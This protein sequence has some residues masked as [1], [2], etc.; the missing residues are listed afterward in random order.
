[1]M[2]VSKIS[3][4]WMRL[5][6]LQTME[7]LNHSQF[8]PEGVLLLLDPQGKMIEH[9]VMTD[10]R[11]LSLETCLEKE[12]AVEGFCHLI[13]AASNVFHS[14]RAQSCMELISFGES[15]TSHALPILDDEQTLAAVIVWLLPE[16]HPHQNALAVLECIHMMMKCFFRSYTCASSPD[17]KFE[18][19]ESKIRQFLFDFTKQLHSLIHVEDVLKVLIEQMDTMYPGTMFKLWMSQDNHMDHLPLHLL[20]FQGNVHDATKRAYIEGKA[21]YDRSDQE[22]R[23]AVPLLG[24]QAVYG[25]IELVDDRGVLDRADTKLISLLADSTGTAFENAKLHEESNLLISELRLINEMTHKLN[26]SLKP[27]EIYDFTHKELIDIFSADFCSV[28]EVDACQNKIGVRAGNVNEL[29]HENFSLDYGISGLMYHSKE[30]LIFSD[31]NRDIHVRSKFMDITAAKSIMA[32]PMIVRSEVIGVILLAHHEPNYFTYNNYRLFQVLSGHIGLAL[33]NAELHAEVKRMVITDRLTGLYA[34]HYLDEQILHMQKKDFNG[35][36]IVVDID[37]FKRIN[38]TYGHQIGD[39][40]LKK[41]SRVI[42][43]CI[44]A[45]DI[46]ARWGGEEI[47]IYLPL[48]KLEDT[49]KVA[50]RIRKRVMKETEPRVTVSCGVSQWSWHD[51]KFSVES[52]FYRADMALYEA[53]NSG[54]NSVKVGF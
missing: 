6:F 48:A 19:K 47:A 23:I 50:E 22:D 13:P 37:F 46:A 26:Q 8:F 4:E 11:D 40:I 41:V 3:K 49:V 39:K 16:R 42:Q 38:D 45:Q 25:V 29:K 43:G 17:S 5:A 18:V 31:Y 1:M 24:K 14:K 12:G 15:Y 32:S 7:G 2:T 10:A 52:L 30:P 51:E 20:N 35:G 34:R 53:K 28:L 54:R 33:V 27:D 36:L 9:H 21:V 44:R